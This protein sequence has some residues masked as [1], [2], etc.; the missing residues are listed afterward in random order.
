MT[1][2]QV[3]KRIRTVAESHKQ[4]RTFGIGLVSDFLNDHTTKYPAVFLQDTGGRISLT[5]HATTL[6]YRLFFLDLVHQ[7]EDAKVNELDVQSDMLSIAQDILSQMNNGTLNDWAISGDNAVQYVVENESDMLAGCIVDISVRIMFKQN[8]CAVP[9]SL[10]LIDLPQTDTDMK[11]VYDFTYVADGTE[12]KNLYLPIVTGKKILL[13]IKENN[14]LFK[15][16][17]NPGSTEYIWD[18]TNIGLGVNTQ[19][20]ERFLILYRN[21]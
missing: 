18:Y 7:S 19:P 9:S 16:S 20:G 3:V 4:V 2:N 10:L 15:V 6:S 17:N 8:V 1:L 11:Q 12:Q 5:G 13:I 14:P 21:I